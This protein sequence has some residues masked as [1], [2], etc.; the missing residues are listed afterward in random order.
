MTFIREKSTST[1]KCDLLD[2]KAA[3]SIGGTVTGHYD[4]TQISNTDVT[5]TNDYQFTLS[6]SSGS[7][8]L[9][10]A[11]FVLNNSGTNQANITFQWYDETNSQYIGGR[12]FLSNYQNN[13]STDPWLPTVAQAIILASDFGGSD[14]TI[15]LRV[16]SETGTGNTFPASVP[17][18]GDRENKPVFRI[19][20]N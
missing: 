18:S 14:I 20:Q 1:I 19:W 3:T 13:G 8:F 5:S 6:S 10:T 7:S 15:S 17:L 11:T 9:V 2:N 16:I 12:G 4:R